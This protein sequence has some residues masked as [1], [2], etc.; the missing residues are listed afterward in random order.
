MNS[1][2]LY[3]EGEINENEEEDDEIIDNDDEELD[4][5]IHKSIK[6]NELHNINENE[7]EIKIVN[8]NQIKNNLNINQPLFNNNLKK[9]EPKL[10]NTTERVKNEVKNIVAETTLTSLDNNTLKLTNEKFIENQ[11]ENKNENLEKKE[12]ENNNNNNNINLDNYSKEDLITLLMNNPININNEEEEEEEEREEEINLNLNFNTKIP[13]EPENEEDDDSDF[14]KALTKV[15]S[16]MAK[17]KNVNNN[18]LYDLLVSDKDIVENELK[19]YNFNKNINISSKIQNYIDKKNKNINE[20]KQKKEEEFKQKYTFTPIIN[21]KNNINNKKRNLNQFLKDQEEYQQKINEKI[22]NIKDS[23]IKKEEEELKLKPKIQITSEKM[24]QEKYKGEEVFKR[25]YNQPQK[26][27]FEVKKNEKSHKNNNNSNVNEE[28]LNN[29]YQDAKLREKKNKEKET[30]ENKKRKEAIQYKAASNSNKYLYNKF[31]NL[32]KIQIEKII[33]KT[34]KKKLDFNQLKVL[35]INLNFIPQSQ[36]EN[37]QMNNLLKEI[38]ENLKDEQGLMS[39]DHIFIFCLSILSLFE[40]YILSN[41]KMNDNISTIQ[42][43]SNETQREIVSSI[44]QK[45]LKYNHSSNKLL[46]KNYSV[47]SVSNNDDI[48]SKLDIINKDLLGRIVNYVKFGGF[49]LD[50]NFIITCNHSKLISKTFISFYQYYNNPNLYKDDIK[51]NNSNNNKIKT[52]KKISTPI[53]NSNNNYHKIQIKERSNRNIIQN[54]SENKRQNK[55]TSNS[56]RLEQ[57]YLESAKKRNHLEKEKEKYLEQKEKEEKKICTFRPKINS[58]SQY[59]NNIIPV[60]ENVNIQELR[61]EMLYKKGTENLL[62]KKDKTLEEIELEKNKKELTFKPNINEVNYNMFNKNLNIDDYDIQKF[63]KRLQKGR[64]ERELRIS[65]LERGEFLINNQRNYSDNKNSKKKDFGFSE[66]NNKK[67]RSFIENK[68]PGKERRNVYNFTNINNNKINI[69]KHENETPIL[70]IDVN[71]KHGMKKKVFVYEGDTSENLAKEFSEE[72]G[73]DNKMR[74]K[75][76]MLI[77][78]EIDKLLT[79]IDEESQSTFKSIN[80]NF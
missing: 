63:N 9:E 39:I 80:K 66:N 76:Q 38:Y 44:S 53:M 74:K 1:K 25:L 20:I 35:F 48:S 52:Y 78:Q 15:L 71:L 13:E 36:S 49:D 14:N 55:S 29:L 10:E 73:L 32:Y 12:I 7:K 24:A 40:Y 60:G 45:N 56:K 41:Y 59:K 67:K 42:T 27:N 22:T 19:K 2:N 77:Q 31:K 8:N 54:S 46:Q 57:L 68:T 70:Q 11:K 3:D 72:N 65:A 50:N 75:L 69:N 64:E 26:K 33:T 16:N 28:Y 79:K 17:N 6:S 51:D 5:S 47:K 43:E 37:E 23:Q 30:L 21:K 4:D 58:N 61:M 34:N 62:N 18:Q